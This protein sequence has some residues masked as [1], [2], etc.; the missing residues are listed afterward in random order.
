MNHFLRA[1]RRRQVGRHGPSVSARSVDGTSS[2]LS[3]GLWRTEEGGL[4]AP[5]PRRHWTARRA[6]VSSMTFQSLLTSRLVAI[7][8]TSVVVA[9]CSAS[10]SSPPAL[11]DTGGAAGSNGGSAGTTAGTGG[12]GGAGGSAGTG[13]TTAGGS[14]AGGNPT[15][16]LPPPT[17]DWTAEGCSRAFSTGQL[18]GPCCIDVAC[19]TPTATAPC[20]DFDS[21]RSQGLISITVGV[22]SGTCPCGDNSGKGGPYSVPVGYPPETGAMSGQCC[23]TSNYNEC[24]GRPLVVEGGVRV[25]AL[26][27]S[28]AWG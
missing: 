14:G 6:T 5:A 26:V 25:A 2:P 18:S 27:R 1:S 28:T 4:R 3:T 8:S 21:A 12:I 17:S 19:Y 7:A 24:T 10:S 13:G 9:A 22:G 16:D 11:S 23:Y 20:L 15:M